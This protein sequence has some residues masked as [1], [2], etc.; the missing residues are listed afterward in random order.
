MTDTAAPTALVAGSIVAS[1]I[2]SIQSSAWATKP[3]EEVMVAC[4][5]GTSE[6]LPSA[7]TAAAR[8]SEARLRTSGSTMLPRSPARGGE[9]GRVAAGGD[10]PAAAGPA[11]APT[12]LH[13]DAELL[14][15]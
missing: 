3:G 13:E 14:R 2:Q 10:G 1:A 4:T 5:S 7:C 12:C 8:T 9:A 15:R 6:R 11:A